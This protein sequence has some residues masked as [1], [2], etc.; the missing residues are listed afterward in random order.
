MSQS[1][2]PY[3]QPAISATTFF[4]IGPAIVTYALHLRD[5]LFLRLETEPHRRIAATPYP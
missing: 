5:T 4:D 2:R 1:M 3:F